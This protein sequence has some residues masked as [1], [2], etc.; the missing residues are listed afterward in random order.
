M[1]L[2][3]DSHAKSGCDVAFVDCSSWTD[4][5]MTGI[6]PIMIDESFQKERKLAG[7]ESMLCR[8]RGSWSLLRELR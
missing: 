3:D 5:L 8:P 4:F 2:G 1:T 6:F 7:E